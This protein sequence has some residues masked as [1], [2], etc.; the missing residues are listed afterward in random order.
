[1]RVLNEEILIQEEPRRYFLAGEP[2]RS[3]TGILGECGITPDFSFVPSLVMAHAIA[4]GNAV[5]HASY[6]IDKDTLDEYSLDERI[7]GYIQAYKRFRRECDIRVIVS[8]EKMLSPLG[9]GMKPDRI[10]WILGQRAILD[11]KTAQ[12]LAKSTGPQTAGY[13][14]GWDSIYPKQLIEA[15]Y[16]LRL[17]ANGTYKLTP[18]EDPEDLSCFMDCLRKSKGEKDP[19]LESR[20]T[21]WRKKYGN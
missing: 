10:A 9:F 19:D 15:R 18:Y 4:R 8:E 20:L 7:I 16:G 12:S 11:L 17:S 13:K 1:M 6:L 21:H 14:I 3:V 5:H 2:Y